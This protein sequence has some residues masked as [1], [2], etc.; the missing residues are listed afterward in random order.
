MPSSLLLF[1]PPCMLEGGKETLLRV[2]RALR[3]GWRERCA[4][5]DLYSAHT[6]HGAGVEEDLDQEARRNCEK[7]TW[8]AEPT[9]ETGLYVY[10]GTGR[11][12]EKQGLPHPA[13]LLAR[14]LVAGKIGLPG[15]QYH[16][17][18][19]FPQHLNKTRAP[20]SDIAMTRSKE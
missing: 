10:S 2:P 18:H 12:A 17:V 5:A 9:C 4:E 11:K 6:A 14:E 3:N 1:F 7:G 13:N 20:R 15:W 16:L 8:Q 19:L